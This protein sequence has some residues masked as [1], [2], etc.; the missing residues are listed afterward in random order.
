MDYFYLAALVVIGVLCYQAG[1]QGHM[2]TD[3]MEAT[4]ERATDRARR[5]MRKDLRE[6]RGIGLAHGSNVME[7]FQKGQHSVLD[8]PDYDDPPEREG[9]VH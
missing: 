7:A 3:D 4:I 9:S 5:Q 8:D 1:R 2:S 6:G